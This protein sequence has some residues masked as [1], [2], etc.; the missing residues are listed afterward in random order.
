MHV[1]VI[2]TPSM[3]TVPPIPP[4]RNSHYSG[5]DFFPVST[6]KIIGDFNLI[7]VYTGFL[8]FTFK[9]NWGSENSKFSVSKSDLHCYS[10][11]HEY[12]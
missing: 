5:K 2:Y 11:R 9:R 4:S 3:P 7:M 1:V 10:G 12:T 8:I 6:G